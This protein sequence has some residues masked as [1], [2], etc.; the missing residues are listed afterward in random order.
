MDV[1]V[2]LQVN[3]LLRG[4]KADKKKKK[5]QHEINLNYGM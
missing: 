4:K 1:N 5:T 3:L 2:E